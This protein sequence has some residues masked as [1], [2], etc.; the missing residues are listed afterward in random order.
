MLNLSGA[1]FGQFAFTY[2]RDVLNR[3]LVPSGHGFAIVLLAFGVFGLIES[4]RQSDDRIRLLNL[5]LVVSFA[6]AVLG[7][8]AAGAAVNYY[9]EPALAMAVLAPTALARLEA[10]WRN[11][12]PLSSFAFVIVL[13]LL[14]PSLDE[15]RSN[16]T[17]LK[18]DD[19]RRVV[20][21]MDRRQVFTD[22]PYLAARTQAPQLIDLASPGEYRKERWLGRLVFKGARAKLGG[23][24]IRSGNSRQARR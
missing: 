7:S 8:A 19:L 13:V 9:L 11:E 20:A 12:S 16:T 4:F 21:L 15:Q 17:H 14:L 24:E 18:S 5:Y 6:L 10:G 3:L 1:K 22:I 2:I 23:E